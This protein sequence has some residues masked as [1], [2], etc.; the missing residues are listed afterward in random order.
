MLGAEAEVAG[1]RGGTVPHYQIRA[2]LEAQGRREAGGEYGRLSTA[3][4]SV[5]SAA[6]TINRGS[7]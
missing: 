1:E 4:V 7:T 3:L 6:L 5:I 2:E